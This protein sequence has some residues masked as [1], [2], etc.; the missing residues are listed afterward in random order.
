LFMTKPPDVFFEQHRYLQRSRRAR[1]Q[2]TP[3]GPMPLIYLN[4]SVQ[5]LHILNCQ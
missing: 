4:E 2:N 5:Q 3:K 1:K